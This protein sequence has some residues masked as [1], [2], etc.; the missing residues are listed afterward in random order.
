GYLE[1]PYEVLEYDV[2][3]EAT[4]DGKLTLKWNRTPGGGGP[5]RGCQV[6]EV[7][8]MKRQ[9]VVAGAPRTR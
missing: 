1:N 8:V 5:G 9:P 7:W 3:A 6:A 2:P 4:R